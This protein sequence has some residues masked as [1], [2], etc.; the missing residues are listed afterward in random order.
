METRQ[1]NS[2]EK[3]FFVFDVESIGLHGE[4][5]AVAGGVYINGKAQ[6]E[7]CFC[8]PPEKATGDDEDREWVKNNVPAIPV[9]HEDPS[10][11]RKSFWFKW[12]DAKKKYPEITM[13]GECIWPV[14]AGFV[15][16]C[17]RQDI[18]E[19]KWSGPYP[20][21]EIASFMLSA[22]MDPMA[23][24][25]RTDSEMPAHE[26]LA[27]ARQSARLLAEALRKLDKQ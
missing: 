3:P 16:A 4:G 8:C 1:N 11:V 21:H 20:F 2:Y 7:F 19:F 6:E 9:T 22:G 25:E 17:I 12:M 23:T 10:G 18:V 24:Y 15:S 5:F 14:E 26:P 27:D 13:A